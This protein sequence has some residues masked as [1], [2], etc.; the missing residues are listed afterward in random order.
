MDK[1]YGNKKL[2][3]FLR[4]YFKNMP[5]S[6]IYKAIRKRD[7]KVNGKRVSE[8]YI[9]LPGDIVQIYVP[10]NILDGIPVNFQGL[11]IVYEDNNILIINKEQGMPVHP[12]RTQNENTLIDYVR[13]YLE[14]KGEYINSDS[15]INS[16]LDSDFN[17]YIDSD[18]H[19]DSN[20]S[21]DYY[22]NSGSY[23]NSISISDSG[24]GSDYDSFFDLKLNPKSSFKP[25]LCHRLDRNTGGLVIIAKNNESRKIILEKL[26]TNE[27][28]KY[29]QCIVKGKMDQVNGELMAFLEKDENKSRVFIH[30]EY[31]PGYVEVITKYRVLSY[32]EN[33]DVSKLEIELVTGRT[34]QVRAH[35]SY[36]G[37]PIVGD[38]KYG[39]NSYNRT[40]G[41]KKQ[42]L[43]SYKITFNFNKEKKDAHI[44]Q[45]LNGKSF[46]IDPKWESNLKKLF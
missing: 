13:S 24:Q 38:G 27:I 16:D 20:H 45:Y 21:S 34:H 36:I 40:I 12:D 42:A 6:A 29:Y 15:V 43:F 18:T 1:K 19:I 25:S 3:S 32:N 8:D 39:I 28:K 17:L 4:H 14:K 33:S 23:S 5:E 7:V 37:H 10:D 44:L 30:D 9:V 46:E 22:L 26:K 31:K 41:V 11:S 2:A 35:L